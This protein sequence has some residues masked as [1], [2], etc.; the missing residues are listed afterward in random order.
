[1]ETSSIA[2]SNK[3]TLWLNKD[4][5]HVGDWT[6]QLIEKKHITIGSKHAG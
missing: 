4:K 3:E 2:V 6:N 1:M 5:N